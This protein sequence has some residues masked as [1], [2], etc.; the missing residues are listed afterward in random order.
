M[1]NEEAILEKMLVDVTKKVEELRDKISEYSE[2]AFDEGTTITD[3]LSGKITNSAVDKTEELDRLVEQTKQLAAVF[4]YLNNRFETVAG[5]LGYDE[6]A[7]RG[8]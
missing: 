2:M 6:R 7:D 3:N 1:K 8:E 4:D 5:D